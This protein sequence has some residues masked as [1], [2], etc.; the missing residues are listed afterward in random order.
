MNEATEKLLARIN[1]EKEFYKALC[2]Y[3]FRLNTV[4]RNGN[5]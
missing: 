3:L 2:H 4:G 1:A 5:R